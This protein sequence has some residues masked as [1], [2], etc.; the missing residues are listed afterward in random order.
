MSRS[1]TGPN[2][3]P[4][5]RK[6]SDVEAERAANELIGPPIDSATSRAYASAIAFT[7]ERR[8]EVRS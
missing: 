1:S 3:T 8:I 4:S 2:A 5:D 7:S 6:V